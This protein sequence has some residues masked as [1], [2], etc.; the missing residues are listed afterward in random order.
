S[1]SVAVT[2]APASGSVFPLGET[3]VSCV[4][5]DAAGNRASGSFTVTITPA[6]APPVE[7][8][9]HRLFMPVIMR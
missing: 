8:A 5:S 3:T 1:G 6:G 9:P 7:P 4:A 2:C